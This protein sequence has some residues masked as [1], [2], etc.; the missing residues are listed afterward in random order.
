MLFLD[1][2]WQLLPGS[3]ILAGKF[4]TVSYQV[5][6]ILSNKID[7]LLVVVHQKIVTCEPGVL[8]DTSMIVK[9][10]KESGRER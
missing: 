10:T 9:S 2:S 7:E 5:E 6:F 4:S 3:L 1:L 8:V